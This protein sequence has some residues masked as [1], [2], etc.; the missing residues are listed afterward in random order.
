MCG[1][2]YNDRIKGVGPGNAYKLLAE[3]G[4]I[5]NLPAIHKKKPLDTSVLLF[6]QSRKMFH[7]ENKI[8]FKI[9]HN[10]SPDLDQLFDWLLQ[11]NRNTKVTMALLQKSFT[12]PKITFLPSAKP[13]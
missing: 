2:D 4:A 3:Y 8:D 5:E 6:E 7:I 1:T 11:N 13:K 12:K 9:R 10:V